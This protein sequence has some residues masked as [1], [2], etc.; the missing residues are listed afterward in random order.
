MDVVIGIQLLLNPCIVRFTRHCAGSK[1]KML[2]AFITDKTGQIKQI[3]IWF[4]HLDIRIHIDST[5]REK[6]IQPDIIRYES[7]LFRFICLLHIGV[8]A[9]VEIVFIP[10]PI[11]II[12]HEFVP[13]VNTLQCQL[14]HFTAAKPT[15]MNNPRYHK[16]L[17]I[18]C[19]I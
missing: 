16:N 9:D 13:G 14:R 6:R 8:T 12:R 2:A 3:V 19:L 17:I 15:I 7:I 1:R 18:A 5:F 11:L 10:E 4:Q